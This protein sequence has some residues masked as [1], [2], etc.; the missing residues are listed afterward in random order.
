MQ[1]RQPALQRMTQLSHGD[2][3]CCAGNAAQGVRGAH[4]VIAYGRMRC[5]AQM[6]VFSV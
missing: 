6:G 1:V 2:K 5:A 4:K 3:S